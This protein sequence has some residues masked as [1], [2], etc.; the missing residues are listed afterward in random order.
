M[1]D[2]KILNIYGQEY[3]HTDAK[4]VGNK[5]LDTVKG[6]YMEAKFEE[7]AVLEL[8]GHRRLAG[9]V[10]DAVIGGGAFLRIDIPGKNG[11]QTT[12][13]YSPQ[14]VYCITPTTEEIARAVAAQNEPAPVYRWELPQGGADMVTKEKSKSQEVAIVEH[15]G[16]S[17]R[18]TWQ[19]VKTLICPLA[20]DQETAI[21]LKTCQA[22]QLSPFHNEI[23]LIKY[24]ERDK[25]AT[26]V[27]IGAYL[28]AAE[29]NENYNGCEAGIILRDSGGKL[30]FREGAF[31]LDDEL[32]KL[33]GGW[34]RVYRKDRDRPTYMAVNKTECVRYT[35][36]G[37]L[38]QFWTRE[39]WASM[40]RKTALKRALVEAFPSLFAGT[41]A[42]TEVADNVPELE[43][44]EL[45]P[46]F[47]KPNGEKNWKHFW[48]KVKSE[49]GLTA[50]EARELLQVDSIKEELIDAGW[51]MERIWNELIAALQRQIISQDEDLFGE[52]EVKADEAWDELVHEAEVVEAEA[53]KTKRDPE[54]IRSIQDL[55]RACHEDFKLQPKEVL[56]ELGYG[57]QSDINETP[58]ILYQKIAAVRA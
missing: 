19:D 45:P 9:R 2:D 27:A 56:K 5:Q 4:I 39:K 10:T 18:I 22:L 29:L 44:G 43:E 48:A 52:S 40:L 32:D 1:A 3:W 12:Q 25:A 36:E 47:E 53:K 15:R 14:S 11:R 58:A 31:V 6:G 55:Y 49:L 54:T 28:K 16:T 21:F 8:M 33:V 26:V 13:Y 42:S 38:T 20:T 17:L 24:S 23:Y 46:A 50:E 37:K 41:L 34:A 30:E 7:W 51:T 57:S 35:R